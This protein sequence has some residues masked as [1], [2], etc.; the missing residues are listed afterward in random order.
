MPQAV[1][2]L[3][4]L[5]QSVMV[6]MWRIVYRVAYI[7][8]GHWIN[9]NDHMYVQNFAVDEKQCPPFLQRVGVGGTPFCH[10]PINFYARKS[11]FEYV[12]SVRIEPDKFI[13]VGTRITYQ[14]TGDAGVNSV[15]T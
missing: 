5:I 7:L 12:H 2:R 14:I 4:V 3:A 8:L 1:G 9:A 11:P 10:P 13:L 15:C 6:N